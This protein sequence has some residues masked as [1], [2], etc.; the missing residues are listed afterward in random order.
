M[1]N[2][3]KSKIGNYYKFFF[4]YNET[5]TVF[6]FH[7]VTDNPSNYQKRDKIFHRKK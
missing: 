7:E 4:D 5:L 2:F 3:L 1:K 6:L